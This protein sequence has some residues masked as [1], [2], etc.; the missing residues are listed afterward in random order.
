MLIDYKQQTDNTRYC[1]RRRIVI[2]SL[3]DSS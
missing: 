1:V 2:G 3:A